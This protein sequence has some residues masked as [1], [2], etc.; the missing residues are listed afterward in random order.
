MVN[1]FAF[2]VIYPGSVPSRRIIGVRAILLVWRQRTSDVEGVVGVGKSEVI[3]ML[4]GMFPAGLSVC[5]YV[6]MMNA[7]VRLPARQG[8]RTKPRTR[9]F[10][11]RA[12]CR[13]ESEVGTR[14][15]LKESAD[16][17]RW[18]HKLVS[19]WLISVK[20]R[21]FWTLALSFII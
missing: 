1:D 5:A 14:I 4:M 10:L 18:L 12:Q 17:E 8:S 7:A 20:F 16:S 21:F 3:S 15:E 2:L 13:K 19:S 11:S 6:S 9:N